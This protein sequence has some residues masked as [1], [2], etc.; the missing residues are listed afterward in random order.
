MP[1][2]TR[3]EQRAMTI[4]LNLLATLL[5]THPRISLAH[6]GTLLAN[7]QSVDQQEP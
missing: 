5:I 6:K 3:A 2:L 1:G 7:G 4:S